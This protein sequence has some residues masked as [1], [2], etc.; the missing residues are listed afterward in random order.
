MNSI[1]HPRFHRGTYCGGILILMLLL[2]GQCPAAKPATLPQVDRVDAQSLL[3]L[4]RRLVEA[5]DTNGAP[6]SK[7]T[8]DALLLL[9]DTPDDAHITATVQRRLDPL[10]IAAVEIAQDGTTK[11]VAGRAVEVE[12]NGWRTVLVKVL[13][14]AGIQSRL[15]FDSPQSRPIPHGPLEDVPNRWLSLNAYDGR[16]LDATLSGLELE[17][18]LVQISST[19]TGERTARLEFNAGVAGAKG[20]QTIRQWKFDK[21]ADGWGQLNDL[22]LEVRDK[23]L[24]LQATGGD[25]YFSAPVQARGKMVLRFW[26]QTDSSDIGQV[27]W[28]TVQLPQPDGQR[29]MNFQLNAGRD[30]EYAIEFPVEGDLRGVRIDPLQGEGKFRIEWI[31]LEYAAG[32]NGTWGGA[33][34]AVHTL[35]STK[36]TFQVVDA[37]GSPCMGCFEI[38]DAQGRVY[39]AQPKRQAPDF[40]F[41]TQIYRESGE[42]IRLPPGAYQV[43]CSHGP[44]SV[45]ETKLITVGEEPL[46]VDYRVRRWIDTAKLG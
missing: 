17:Y 31:S 12:E 41:Q 18:R 14:R 8:Q 1:A 23:A 16:P 40:F 28:W 26:G 33:D 24:H 3:L 5:L 45:P 44:E 30:Q 11:A 46:T 25:P 20:S 27:N 42:V 9:K 29:Q 15:R 37:D 35:P 36:V 4:T 38:R 43:V 22:K 13:N 21:D 7:E 10:C 2:G 32:E 39:P 19:R 34:I 6:L